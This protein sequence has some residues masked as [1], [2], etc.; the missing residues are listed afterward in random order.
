MSDNPTAT[1][2]PF[3]AR[4]T[5]G[6]CAICGKNLVKGEWLIY[7]IASK[8]PVHQDCADGDVIDDDEFIWEDDNE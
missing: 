5:K 7:T 1:S 8:F 3:R 4:Q 6:W 2:R